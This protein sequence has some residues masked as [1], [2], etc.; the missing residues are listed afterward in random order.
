MC[1]KSV[2]CT[3]LMWEVK[4]PYQLETSSEL[5]IDQFFQQRK[6]LTVAGGVPIGM[7]KP[8]CTRLVLTHG[9]DASLCF[10]LQNPW[11]GLQLLSKS[12]TQIHVKPG[13]EVKTYNCSE[14]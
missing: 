12:Q 3:S 1:F 4:Y 8:W 9:T 14:R 11:V 5:C 10:S 2:L 13:N 6:G 7:T